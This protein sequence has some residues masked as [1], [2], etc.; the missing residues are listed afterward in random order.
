[1]YKWKR[2][3]IFEELL[4]TILFSASSSMKAILQYIVHFQGLKENWSDIPIRTRV[5]QTFL[6]WLAF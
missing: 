1:M 3:Y 4:V 5:P 6:K 2:F